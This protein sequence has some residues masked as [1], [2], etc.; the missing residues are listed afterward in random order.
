MKLLDKFDASLRIFMRSTIV[1][2]ERNG[3]RK[4]KIRG[5][6]SFKVIQRCHKPQELAR[7]PYLAMQKR[8]AKPCS[9]E[10]AVPLFLGLVSH[11]N[12]IKRVFRSKNEMSRSDMGTSNILHTSTPIPTQH[13]Q[14]HGISPFD[15]F[16][17]CVKLFQPYIKGLFANKTKTCH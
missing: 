15:F 12:K 8:N 9:A 5:D 7:I 2:A 6:D 17:F 3:N 13:P 1:I 11:K 16:Q 14:S 10:H 4:T